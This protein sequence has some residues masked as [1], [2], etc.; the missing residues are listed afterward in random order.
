[1]PVDELVGHYRETFARERDGNAGC[2]PT[3][4]AE[5]AADVTAAGVMSRLK[6]PCGL[7]AAH[8]NVLADATLL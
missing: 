3:L 5:I 4:R 8:L 6:L 7:R 2:C 1:M